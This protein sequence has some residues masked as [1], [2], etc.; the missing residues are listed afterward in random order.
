M[1]MMRIMTGRASLCD[2]LTPPYNKNRD[3]V[4]G[5]VS[6]MFLAGVPC[7]NYVKRFCE[8]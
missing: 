5:D 4:K 7:A 8:I 2:D 6:N 1:N 3:V